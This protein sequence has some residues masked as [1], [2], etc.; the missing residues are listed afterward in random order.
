MG[1]RW[2]RFKVWLLGLTVWLIYYSIFKTWRLTIHEPPEM[3]ASLKNRSPLVL[4]HWHG[5]E[6]VL[7]GLIERYR[8]AT[9]VSTSKDGDLMTELVR[10]FKG[11]S[12][13]GSSTRQG[14]GAL[15]GLV[16]MI[17]GEGLNSSL[18]VD[19]PKGPIYVVKP[20]VFELARLVGCPIIAGGTACDRA[21]HFP[22]AWNKTYLPKPF[23]R[24]HV[25][26]GEL[27]P[28]TKDTD[29]RSEIMAQDLANALHHARATA[30]NSLKA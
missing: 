25:H 17:R 4:A 12:T 26:W 28:I 20:G 11:R 2:R 29:P 24:V 23:A 6:L 18:A 30:A 16:K 5:D 9:M 10:R 27:F 7:M 14:I 13:R 8:T 3:Q 19:G 22:K 1:S 21:W 15:I